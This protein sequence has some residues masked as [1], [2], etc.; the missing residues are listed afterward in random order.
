[1][2]GELS[3]K[4]H[5]NYGQL[6]NIILNSAEDLI[7]QICLSLGIDQSV[8]EGKTGRTFKF[9]E[10]TVIRVL[11][12]STYHPE[13]FLKNTQNIL[14]D[15]RAAINLVLTNDLLSLTERLR[16]NG[17]ELK[18]ALA[19]LQFALQSIRNQLEELPGLPE[20]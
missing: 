11:S 15:R 14:L 20:R 18:E 12:I 8:E 5:D 3:S 1:M 2:P 9:T 7:A 13:E 6:P 17:K 19:D 10:A 16:T 4:V